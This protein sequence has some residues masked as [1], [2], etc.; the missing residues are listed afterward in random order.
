VRTLLLYALATAAAPTAAP[1]AAVP[2][3]ADVVTACAHTLPASAKGLAMLEAA[4]PGLQ[5]ALTQLGVRPLLL[6]SS[7]NNLRADALLDL[8]TLTGADQ[9]VRHAPRLTTLGPILHALAPKPSPPSWWDLFKLWLQRVF[10]GSPAPDS[11]HWLTLWLA[12]LTP[13]QSVLNALLGVL[14]LLLVAGAVMVVVRELRAAGVLSRRQRQSQHAP[15]LLPQ[16]LSEPRTLAQVQAAPAAQQATL[17]FR[18]L[19][20]T[21]VAHHRLPDDRS[22]THR[23]LALRARIDQ[24]AQRQSWVSV[25]SLAERQLLA[26]TAPASPDQGRILRDGEALYGA[27]QAASGRSS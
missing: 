7:R 9:G 21:L 23:E 8:L 14:L 5:Q 1:A 24:P 19:V 27:L 22:L 12:K 25:C 16:T 18:L 17:M 10:G 26:A 13:S 11:S 3:A 2:A 20:E 15:R 4:C 6:Q